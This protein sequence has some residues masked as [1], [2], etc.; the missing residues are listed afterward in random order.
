M[1]LGYP[2]MKTKTREEPDGKSVDMSP[3]AVDQRLRDVSDLW[4]LWARLEL[5]RQ[6]GLLVVPE[7]TPSSAPPREG[8]G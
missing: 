5:D 2:P 8:R 4:D 3:E 6:D 7:A 1:P